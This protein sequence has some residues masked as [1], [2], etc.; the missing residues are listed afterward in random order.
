MLKRRNDSDMTSTT[1][2][3]QGGQLR[4]TIETIDR[5]DECIFLMLCRLETMKDEIK[6]NKTEADA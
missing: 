1:Y 5:L 6:R 2:E 4:R 3:K